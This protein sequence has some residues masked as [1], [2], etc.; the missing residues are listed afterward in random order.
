MPAKRPSI[1]DSNEKLLESARQSERKVETLE[2][3]TTR[4]QNHEQWVKGVVDG[5][6]RTYRESEL[7]NSER[8]ALAL[9]VAR[10]VGVDQKLVPAELVKRSMSPPKAEAGD[11]KSAPLEQKPMLP[12]YQRLAAVIA[13][14]ECLRELF[15]VLSDLGV[16]HL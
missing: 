6:A 11:Q 3:L 13:V 4:Q 9:A 16:V 12:R 2:Q 10:A 7:R 1:P 5:I 14:A 15:H 8:D